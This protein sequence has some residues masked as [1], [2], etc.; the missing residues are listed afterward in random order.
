MVSDSRGSTLVRTSV[1]AS[2]AG[3]LSFDVSLRGRL[4][5]R[6]KAILWLFC[7][8]YQDRNLIVSLGSV[9]FFDLS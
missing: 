2:R 1:S 9:L 8:F 7:V 3:R 4:G 6:E 5:F